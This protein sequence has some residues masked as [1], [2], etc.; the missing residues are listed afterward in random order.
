MAAV[1]H[2]TGKAPFPQRSNMG[3]SAT[4]PDYNL[5]VDAKADRS[6]ADLNTSSKALHRT[7]LK[8]SFT[9]L[10]DPC[11]R[12]NGTESWSMMDAVAF[13]LGRGLALIAANL[14]YNDP[15]RRIDDVSEFH[16]K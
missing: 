10:Q 14:F 6:H 13:T 12:G 7:V 9:E 2:Y 11:R 8:K 5:D 16:D 3:A 15:L 1:T 4:F